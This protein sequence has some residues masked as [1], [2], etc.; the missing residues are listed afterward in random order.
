MVKTDLTEIRPGV[1][2]TGSKE[3]L[4]VQFWTAMNLRSHKNRIFLDKLNNNKH[5]DRPSSHLVRETHAFYGMVHSV[6]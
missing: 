5:H 1:D 2:L 6:Q 4:A 3:S